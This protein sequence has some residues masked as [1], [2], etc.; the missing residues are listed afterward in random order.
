MFKTKD[1][2]AVSCA[3]HRFNSGFLSKDSIRFDKKF[4]G[5]RA[6][7]DLLYAHFLESNE[8]KFKNPLPKLKVNKDD[9]TMADNVIDYLKGLSFKAIERKLT[10]FESNVLNLVNSEYIDKT[11]LGI[12][13]SLPKVYYNKIE[14][15]AWTDRELELSRT[16]LTVGTLHERG[17]FDVTI[18]FVRYIPRTM[19]Y[20]ITCSVKGQHILK[21]FHSKNINLGDTINLDG[22]VKSHNKGRY[23]NGMETVI[24]RVKISS[25]LNQ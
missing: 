14:Q 4:E 11:Q 12:T 7:S 8:L 2:I 3:A 13:S 15:D 5:K 24:N 18:E 17:N 10:E 6:N 21:F 20:L 16:S 19:S 25:E 22:Y 23:H 9:L 1:V